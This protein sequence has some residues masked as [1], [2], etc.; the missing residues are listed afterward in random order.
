MLGC[1]GTK[2]RL[3]ANTAALRTKG[4]ASTGVPFA[5]STSYNEIIHRTTA[6]KKMS[7]KFVFNQKV[8]LY[9][10]RID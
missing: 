6:V 7:T 3:S 9:P 4:V 10:S 2:P 8:F 1:S 5:F